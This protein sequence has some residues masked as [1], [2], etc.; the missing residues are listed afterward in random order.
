MKQFSIR[1]LLFL[2]VIVALMLGWWLDRRPVPSRFQMQATSS[3][4]YVVDTATG[5]VWSQHTNG[6]RDPKPLGN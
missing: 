5:Q 6:F 2:I 1:D 3:T 4:A